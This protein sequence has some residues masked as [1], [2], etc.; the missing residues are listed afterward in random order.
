MCH[1]RYIGLEIKEKMKVD[2]SYITTREQRG[3]TELESVS[4]QKI[5]KAMQHLTKKRGKGDEKLRPTCDVDKSK[6]VGSR[7]QEMEG[8]TI[9]L[10]YY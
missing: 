5:W 8:I 6:A 1:Q 9:A 10:C 7:P 4:L 3:G 2:R